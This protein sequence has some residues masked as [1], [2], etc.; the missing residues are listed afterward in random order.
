MKKSFLPLAILIA[1]TMATSCTTFVEM[2]RTFPQEADLPADSARF[3]FI[4]FYDYQDP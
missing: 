4:N 2:Q 1:A 3:V